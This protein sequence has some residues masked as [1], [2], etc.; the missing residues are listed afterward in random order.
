KLDAPYYR[1]V[2]EAFAARPRCVFRGY[3][4]VMIFR[5]GVIFAT[6]PPSGGKGWEAGSIP[7][8]SGCEA[9]AGSA[10]LVRGAIAGARG[11]GFPAPNSLFQNIDD[12]FVD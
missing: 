3:P 7:S 2:R 10:M 4:F 1:L 9:G 12:Q 6:R 5:A 11:L 8:R